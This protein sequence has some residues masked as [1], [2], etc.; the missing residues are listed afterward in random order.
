MIAFAAQTAAPSGW[1]TKAP[2]SSA[3][4]R[5][6]GAEM[7]LV[8][9]RFNQSGLHLTKERARDAFQNNFVVSKTSSGLVYPFEST[10]WFS[11]FI[12]IR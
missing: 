3:M 11:F 5:C 7:Q 2:R 6:L 8:A 10:G 12:L 9:R 4:R 1:Q